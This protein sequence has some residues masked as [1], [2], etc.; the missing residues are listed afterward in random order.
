M[1]VCKA[2]TLLGLCSQDRVK[3]DTSKSHYVLVDFEIV[4]ELQQNSSQTS[5]DIKQ[6][7]VQKYNRF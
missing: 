1:P 3:R 2:F 7:R 5:Q 6:V 4:I